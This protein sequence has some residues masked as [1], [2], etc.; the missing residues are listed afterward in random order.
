MKNWDKE[1]IVRLYRHGTYTQKQ[2]AERYGI[3]QQ[4]IHQILKR[5]GVTKPRNNKDV[6]CA[7]G[8]PKRHKDKT[9]PVCYKALCLEAYYNSLLCN[10]RDPFHLLCVQKYCTIPIGEE[11][12]IH[13]KEKYGYGAECYMVFRTQ[14]DHIKYH[15]QELKG[16]KYRIRPIWDGKKRDE[17]YI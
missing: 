1:E 6:C 13:L 15:W 7:C 11:M 2:L 3:T 17:E 8:E 16:E 10:P 12:E 4:A 5:A 14:K 9:L